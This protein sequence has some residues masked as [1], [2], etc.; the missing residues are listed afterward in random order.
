MASETPVRDPVFVS[1]DDLDNGQTAPPDPR[2]ENLAPLAAST[3][4]PET[5]DAL[6]KELASSHAYAKQLESKLQN[7]NKKLLQLENEKLSG[8]QRLFILTT[9]Y[10]FQISSGD[11]NWRNYNWNPELC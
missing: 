3:P 4:S 7:A 5:T 1:V 6:A 10:H 9:N 11:F 8:F 2:S